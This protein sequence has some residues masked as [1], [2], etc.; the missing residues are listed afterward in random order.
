MHGWRLA[1]TSG[2]SRQNTETNTQWKV[3]VCRGGSNWAQRGG[4]QNWAQRGGQQNQAIR[5]TEMKQR[6]VWEGQG[7]HAACCKL[8]RTTKTT[9]L[10]MMK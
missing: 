7:P 9:Y 6:Y 8:K 2:R 1:N 4:Q 10:N 5:A 3:S